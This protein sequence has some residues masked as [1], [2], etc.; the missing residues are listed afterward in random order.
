MESPP[1]P[2]RASAQAQIYS[3]R[4]LPENKKGRRLS[5]QRTPGSEGREQTIDLLIVFSIMR[6]PARRFVAA[7]M[8]N[9]DTP[10][11][12][13]GSPQVPLSDAFRRVASAE[14]RLVPVP[15]VQCGDLSL[16]NTQAV[17]CVLLSLL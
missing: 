7:T 10:Y 6:G 13:S 3:D 11:P 2:K 15:D 8:G 12:T 16:S 14:S 17:D 9:R 1:L 4:D 5:E